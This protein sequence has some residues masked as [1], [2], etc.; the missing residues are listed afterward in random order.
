MF[1]VALFPQA[2]SALSDPYLQRV[3]L[4]APVA[5][6]GPLETLSGLPIVRVAQRYFTVRLA[7]RLVAVL[8]G[9]ESSVPPLLLYILVV[10]SCYSL[11]CLQSSRLILFANC[12]FIPLLQWFSLL[13]LLLLFI[14]P[15]G[16]LL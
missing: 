16:L 8:F 6:V 3:H 2:S 10:R 12:F 13:L 5:K 4:E 11:A 7:E 14:L 1:S 9:I 15:S